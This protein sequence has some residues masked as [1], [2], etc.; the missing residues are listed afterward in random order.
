M[1]RFT[2]LD[3]FQRQ[4]WNLLFRATVEQKTPMRTPA[5]ATIDTKGIPQ[6]RTVVLR[7]SDAGNRSLYY[8][9]DF[10]SEK[11]RE[12]DHQARASALFWDPKRHIQLRC[13]GKIAIR[14][15]DKQALAFWQHISL[16]GRKAYATQRPPGTPID[17]YSTGLPD[18]WPERGLQGSEEY[19][20]NFALLVHQIDFMDALHLEREGHQRAQF[21]WQDEQWGKTWL[22]P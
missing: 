16:H 8:F 22:V 13:T 2:T 4:A 20:V 21:T 1:E 17:S 10:R 9:T 15:N 14:H 7:K 6:A 12:L 19:K 18:N 5:L 11:C 3:D